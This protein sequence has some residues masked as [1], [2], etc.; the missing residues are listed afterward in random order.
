CYQLVPSEPE[1]Q[2]LDQATKQSTIPLPKPLVVQAFNTGATTK[3]F[4]L[5]MGS[6]GFGAFNACAPGGGGIDHQ[7]ASYPSDGQPGGGG[8]K[9][10][11]DSGNGPACKDQT[12]LVT[13]AT[14]GSP[15]CQSLVAGAC[16]QIQSD[17]PA[18]QDETRRSCIDSNKPDSLY[19]QNW[20]VYA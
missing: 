7:Y 19:H 11:G 18:V 6:G 16:N 15:A 2:V 8:V 12:N 1:V 14:V 5:F 4:D 13:G 20:K 10:V 9:A 17:T 3:T